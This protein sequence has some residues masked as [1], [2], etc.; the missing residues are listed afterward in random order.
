MNWA[1]MK[2]AAD[3]EAVYAQI[4]EGTEIL[5]SHQPPYGFGDRLVSGVSR[6]VAARTHR[7][8]PTRR[9]P[10]LGA[11]VSMPLEWSDLS[12]SPERWTLMAVPR[13]LKRLRD[14]PWGRAL[15][16]RSVNRRRIILSRASTLSYGSAKRRDT[17]SR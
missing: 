16:G 3:L 7:C 6:K 2:E 13:R 9:A 10:D 4:P 14:D 11:M 17:D 8:V 1:F 5:V 15:D 12:A